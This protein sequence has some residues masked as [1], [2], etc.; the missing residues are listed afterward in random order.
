MVVTY[1]PVITGHECAGWVTM[2]L[3]VI[4]YIP[5]PR[6]KNASKLNG[7]PSETTDFMYQA[8]ETPGTLHINPGFRVIGSALHKIL[9]LV[10]SCKLSLQLRVTTIPD[11]I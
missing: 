9:K 10:I 2:E 5:C 7:N 4:M 11:Q 8:M 3:W 1:V 6:D